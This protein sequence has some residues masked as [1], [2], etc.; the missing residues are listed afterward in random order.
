MAIDVSGDWLRDVQLRTTVPL[1]KPRPAASG[2]SSE[3]PV[4]P[5]GAAP[6]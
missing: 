2:A 1:D 3:R 5:A 6:L 4:K